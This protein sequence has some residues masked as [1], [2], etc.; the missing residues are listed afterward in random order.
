[1]T[2]MD[3]GPRQKRGYD[4][5]TGTYHT[6]H[7]WTGTVPVN[8]TVCTAVAAL[9]GEDVAAMSPLAKAI[10]PDALE[11]LFEPKT[12]AGEPTDHTTFTYDG[13]TVTVFRSGHIRIAP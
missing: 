4:P 5:R 3:R 12:A 1:M 8:Y 13:C 11:S 10:E 6:H 9:T 2:S 7:D